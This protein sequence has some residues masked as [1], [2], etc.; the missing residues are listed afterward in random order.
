[1][2][3]HAPVVPVGSAPYVVDL[4][5]SPTDEYFTASFVAET[6]TSEVFSLISVVG[7]KLALSNGM[8]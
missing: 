3:Q 5:D 6:G 7:G 2:A 4:N 8:T 1:M